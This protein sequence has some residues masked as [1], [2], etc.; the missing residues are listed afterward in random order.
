M[1]RTPPTNFANICNQVAFN[2]TIKYFQQSLG[3]LV[4]MI[5]DEEK[6]AVK[7]EFKKF[8]LNDQQLAK[9]VSEV[10]KNANNEFSIMYPLEKV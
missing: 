2:N 3:V 4:S 10:L 6:A 7:R 1:V 8:I 5:R 9:K